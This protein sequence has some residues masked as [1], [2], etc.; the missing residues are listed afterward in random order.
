MHFQNDWLSLTSS[1]I[2]KTECSQ[3]FWFVA[4][5]AEA[6]YATNK[7]AISLKHQYLSRISFLVYEKQFQNAIFFIS[8]LSQFIYYVIILTNLRSLSE[9]SNSEKVCILIYIFLYYKEENHITNSWLH[10]SSEDAFT[11]DFY[12]KLLVLIPNI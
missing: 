9:P 4:Q 7:A 5:W 2:R 8:H 6:L 3:K 11:R 1:K 12:R 10:F